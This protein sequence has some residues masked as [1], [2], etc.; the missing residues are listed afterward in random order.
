MVIKF[1][2]KGMHMSQ[3]RRGDLYIRVK[4]NY[5]EIVFG[6]VLEMKKSDDLDADLRA[7]DELMLHERS[8]FRRWDLTP[9]KKK[10][11]KKSPKDEL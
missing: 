1:A 9:R 5:F 8:L 7:E 6:D 4:V 11:S 2:D 3:V 10:K